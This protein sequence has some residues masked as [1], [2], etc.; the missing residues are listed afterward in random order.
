MKGV[1]LMKNK[2]TLE[3]LIEFNQSYHQQHGVTESDLEKCLEI[4]KVFDDARDSQKSALAGD[5]VIL[6]GTKK[7]YENGHIEG[8]NV[9]GMN[10][11]R[12]PDRL[13]ICVKAYV[14][15]VQITEYGYCLDTSGG[16]W[17]GAEPHEF[18]DTGETREKLF[19]AW[20]HCGMT[21]NGAFHFPYEVKVWE[22]ESLDI[23]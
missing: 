23:Y 17:L 22:L 3:R 7:T 4:V 6:K 12:N 16:Y 13:S 21:G 1:K 15:F 2:I 18:K 11:K 5:V 19:K 9:W 14:P 8:V 10:A 20:G